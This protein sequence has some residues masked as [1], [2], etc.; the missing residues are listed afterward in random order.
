MPRVAPALPGFSEA[1]IS[2]SLLGTAV[3]AAVIPA[4]F[5]F[6]GGMSLQIGDAYMHGHA[7]VAVGLGSL[8]VAAQ[9]PK[10][11]LGTCLGKPKCA[12]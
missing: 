8:L 7:T 3:G 11:E 12:C 10:L 1:T 9:L 2:Y 6:S 5:S 4:G